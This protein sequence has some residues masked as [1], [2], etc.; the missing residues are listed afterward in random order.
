[1]P[2]PIIW[3][4]DSFCFCHALCLCLLCVITLIILLCSQLFAVI[5]FAAAGLVPGAAEETALLITILKGSATRSGPFF[6]RAGGD[7][8]VEATFAFQKMD[9][10]PSNSPGRNFPLGFIT[11]FTIL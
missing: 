8:H 2:S 1:M 11:K 6:S 4:G 10:V 9:P 3:K 7:F 5:I